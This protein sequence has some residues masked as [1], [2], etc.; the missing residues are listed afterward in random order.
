MPK[1]RMAGY[2]PLKGRTHDD[3]TPLTQDPS[4]QPVAEAGPEETVAPATAAPAVRDGVPYEQR[5][6]MAGYTPFRGTAPQALTGG[7]QHRATAAQAPAPAAAEPAAEPDRTAAVQTPSPG[8]AAAVPAAVSGVPYEQR[9]RMAGY[10]PLKGGAPAAPVAATTAAAPRTEAA[11]AAEATPAERSAALAEGAGTAVAGTAAGVAAGG[12]LAASANTDAQ[13]ATDAQAPAAPV[14]QRMKGYTPLKGRTAGAA[15]QTSDASVQAAPAAPAAAEPPSS[16]QAP[17]QPAADAQPARKQRMGA[18]TA[19]AAGGAAAAGAAGA[20]AAHGSGQDTPAAPKHAAQAP[21]GT[22]HQG[23]AHQDSAQQGAA[24]PAAAT[25]AAA[26]KA[27]GKPAGRPAAQPTKKA[28]GAEPMPRGRKVLWGALGAVVVAL[29]LV[30]AARGLRTLE[31]VQDFIAQY[32][33]HT[34]QPESAPIGIPAWLGWQHFLNMFLMVLII[35]TGLQ[36]RSEQRPPANFTPRRDSLFSAKGNT[37]KKYSMTIWMHQA[38]DGLWVLNG[39]LFVILLFVTGQ[40]MRL[41]PTDPYVFHHALSAGIQYMSLDWPSENGWVHYNALQMITY[42]LVVFVAAPLAALTG[43]RMS[44]WF[45]TEAKALN[46]A[47]PMEA[48]R[49]VHFP[50]MLFFVG[51]I[52]VHVFLVVFTGFLANLNHMYT[53]REATDA[54]GLVVFLASVAVTA[55]AWFFLRP[56]FVAPVAQRFGTVGR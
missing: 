40:W 34:A 20:A 26:P 33:G 35:R 29:A 9:Q 50:V 11:A 45:P 15:A 23:T 16:A 13:A 1:Q 4:P 42:T 22:A 27:A 14:G 3:A 36:I 38:L 54:W 41:V 12:D 37:P 18:G 52:V 7:A 25:S 17:A 46:R 39:L 55:A 44:S 8:A 10:T 49:R 28:E 43:W 51:F 5:Q 21:P 30:L 24:Q 2:T 31:P 6:R 56:Q 19:A 48:A 53:S 47:F 32:D